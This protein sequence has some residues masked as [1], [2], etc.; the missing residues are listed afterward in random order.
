MSQP[1]SRD[2]RRRPFGDDR[3]VGVDLASLGGRPVGDRQRR[4]G[5]TETENRRF[6][7]EFEWKTRSV[8]RRSPAVDARRRR[9][10]QRLRILLSGG[11]TASGADPKSVLGGVM[12]N[13]CIVC[14]IQ[15]VF[16]HDWRG[17]DDGK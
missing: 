8:Q 7:K 17:V 11:S 4:H 16:I 14:T 6:R 13:G 9:I 10:P 15:G 1:R 2:D 12:A 5:R 3:A